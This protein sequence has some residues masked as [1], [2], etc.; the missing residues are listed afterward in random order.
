MHFTLVA[1]RYGQL[2]AHQY[3]VAQTPELGRA[4]EIAEQ[5]RDE[6]AGKYGVAVY[7][8]ESEG[9]CQRVAYY[10][11]QAKEA[12]P[13]DNVRLEQYL[14]LGHWLVDAVSRREIRIADPAGAEPNIP[15][16][17]DIPSWIEE[18]VRDCLVSC[19][20]SELLATTPDIPE[21]PSPKQFRVHKK[22]FQ[23]LYDA[24]YEQA[25]QQVEQDLALKRSA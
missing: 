1:Y 7:Q 21:C 25:Q 5:A 9:S 16:A 14:D 2:N 10:P 15:V 19:R 3:T 11:S 4:L 24:L 22:Q 12:E 20:Y 8:W 6:R 17:V 18:A 13:A 23:H